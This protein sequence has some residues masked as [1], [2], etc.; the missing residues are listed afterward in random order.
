MNDLMA[1]DIIHITFLCFYVP[2]SS[3]NWRYHQIKAALQASPSAASPLP[4]S[5]QRLKL[6]QLLALPLDSHQVPVNYTNVHE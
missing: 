6:L 1:V 4:T 3:P 5:G 2:Q